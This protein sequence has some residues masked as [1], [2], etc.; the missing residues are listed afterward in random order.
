MVPSV[1]LLAQGRTDETPATSFYKW[2]RWGF[3]KLHSVEDQN[4]SFSLH[5]STCLLIWW[6]SDTCDA[7]ILSRPIFQSF[8]FIQHPLCIMRGHWN[9]MTVRAGALSLCNCLVQPHRLFAKLVFDWSETQGRK[10]AAFLWSHNCW[11]TKAQSV[12]ALTPSLS[13]FL[14]CGAKP[15]ETVQG[16]FYSF[17]FCV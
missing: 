7:E 16:L 1:E 14:L 11:V 2:G 17:S 6:W 4:N 13:T 12:A 15:M 3:W 10:T 8:K 9:K 5:S